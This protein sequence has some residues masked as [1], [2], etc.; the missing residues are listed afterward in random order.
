MRIPL[1][2]AVVFLVVAVAVVI[3]SDQ[4]VQN[5][6]DDRYLY[7]VYT[8]AAGNLDVVDVYESHVVNGAPTAMIQR[9]RDPV[10]GINKSWGFNGK[11]IGPFNCF[12]AA[13]NIL[14][15]GSAYHADD[16]VEKRKN[17][18]AGT[19]AY[20]LDPN[21]L[22][23]TL[24]GNTYTYDIYNVMLIV[25]T[26]YWTS[27]KVTMDSSMGNLKE[28]T[29]Y[30]VLYLSSSSTYTPSG[31]AEIS[32]MIAYAHS[33]SKVSGTT[34][35][36]SNVFPYLGIGVYESYVTVSGDTVGS[37]MLVSQSGRIPASNVTV[38]AFKDLTD[39]LIPVQGS[40]VD[41]YY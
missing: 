37:D 21:D 15:D 29:E 36:N 25:P 3:I 33:A 19:I 9:Y 34:D 31:Q 11:G 16:S 26:V 20:V 6:D 24:A 14:D 27:A 17:T 12:Y 5:S 18:A 30:N 7:A 40:K 10:T 32:G 13:V 38:D 23:K 4:N 28:G 2:I 22:G 8:D 35:F 1:I 39:F 41:S